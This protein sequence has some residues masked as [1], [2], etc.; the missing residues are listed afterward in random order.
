M[1]TIEEEIVMYDSHFF[2]TMMDNL[3]DGIYILDDKG[4]YIFVNSAYIQYLNMSKS[5]LL[6]Y[7]AYEFLNTGQTD[8]CISDIVYREKRQVVMFQDVQ[9]TQNYGR[10]SMRI[11]I[12]STPIFDQSGNVRNILA[13]VRPLEKM[14][15]LYYQACQNTAASAFLAHTSPDPITGASFIAVSSVMRSVLSSSATVATVDSAIL[16]TGESGTGKE[17]VAQFIHAASHRNAKP[18]VVINCASLPEN[19]LE[20]E[21]FG[22]EKGAFTGAAPGGKDGLFE[23]ADGGTLFLDEINS[24]PLNL[25][26]KVLR[27][28][29]TKTIQRVGATH[30]KAVD[31]RL[32]S[33][34]NEEL[35]KLVAEKR[36]RADLY[37]RLAVIPIRLPPLRERRE[38]IVPLAQHFL[39]QFCQKYMKDKIFTAQTL[40]NISK[41]AW[42]GNVRELKNFVERS[43]VMSI[44]KQIE[45]QDVNSFV[46]IMQ[47]HYHSPHA[48]ENSCTSYMPAL[49]AHYEHMLTSGVSLKQYLA[50]CERGYI[51]YALK[52]YNN[53]YKSAEAL[54]TSQSAII[55]RKKKYFS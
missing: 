18:M 3:T 1:Q 6:R 55:R 10:K 25:Q 52:K 49:D 38:D 43:V 11:L 23:T 24:L 13:V 20:A 2:E 30:C 40:S 21:L 15:N 5:V 19:L 17:V 37:Y 46:D 14:N 22:Y 33:A 27:A 45:I 32:I 4:N 29:E 34:S 35:A 51:G 31:F 12:I 26:S 16:L 53:S 42:P 50:Q 9:D 47:V 8:I 54:K 44:D 41:Y 7:N 39:D 48:E 28:I 36:F